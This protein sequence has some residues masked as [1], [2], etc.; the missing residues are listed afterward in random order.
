MITDRQLEALLTSPALGQADWW[1][2][3]AKMGTPLRST[4]RE[5]GQVKLTFLWQDPAGP[6]DTS[7]T[8]A[9]YID[10]YSHTPHLTRQLTGFRRLADTDVWYW[11]TEAATDWVGSYLL[12]PV[13][14]TA[15]PAPEAAGLRRR[16]WIGL[17]AA[18][19]CA[20]RYNPIPGHGNGWGVPLSAILPP[21]VEPLARDGPRPEP[22]TW[23][24]LQLGNKRRLWH[25]RPGPETVAPRPLVILLD[26][27]YWADPLPLFAALSAQTGQQLPPAHYLFVDA[28]SAE[29]RSTE[30]ACHAGFW[31]ALIEEV[32][33]PLQHQGLITD[34]PG[35]RLVAGQSFGGLAAV[36]AALH[37]PDQFGLALS[38]S[39]SFWWP[40]P[41]ETG[42]QGWLVQ[43][44]KT[45]ALV[46]AGQR[47]RLEV[48]CYETDMLGVNRALYEA[49]TAAG[50]QA[51]YQQMRGGHD[52]LCWSQQLLNGIRALLC[53][54]FLSPE[55]SSENPY[56][57]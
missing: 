11:Q 1:A 44:V 31:Q 28:L 38:Q 25:F 50:F 52:G 17:M 36:Y 42:D 43:Q 22:V 8:G 55:S 18:H 2:E 29:Q 12:L 3:V 16:W 6:A 26:G 23:S 30:L 15:L 53:A 57:R 24:S 41:D 39:G 35:Q 13:P 40:N 46:D 19:A 7:E 51:D 33:Q 45:A 37:L 27:H 10:M 5:P 21:S 4:S 56:E 47:I 49:L 54:P 32:L 14:V 48:G 9:V 34:Q 20:D